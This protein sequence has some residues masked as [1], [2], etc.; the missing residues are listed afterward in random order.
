MRF[1]R[2]VW[3]IIRKDLTLELRTKEILSSMFIFTLLVMVIFNFSFQ[4]EKTDIKRLSSGILW[5][6]FTFAGVL[7]LSRSFIFEKDEHCLDGLLLS[8]IDRGS[9]YLGKMLANLIFMLIVEAIIFPVFAVFF[10]FDILY[11]IPQL[12]PI[13]FLSTLGFAAVGTIF[14]A[15]S[16]NTRTREIML[17][18]LLFPVMVPVIISAVRSTANVLKGGP[19]AE[20]VSWLKLLIAFDAIFLVISFLSFDFVMEE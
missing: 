16:V 13:F 6:A 10:D 11:L 14:S 3:L 7:G 8:P 4:G 5:V 9:I 2:K 19:F 18:L 12:I 17:P 15:I 20:T 1:L